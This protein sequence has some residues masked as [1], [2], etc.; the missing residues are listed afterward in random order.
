MIITFPPD[1]GAL[2]L[3]REGRRGLL[4]AL[5]MHCISGPLL[6]SA[7]REI[8]GVQ[9][10]GLKSVFVNSKKNTVFS[11]TVVIGG[12]FCLC[13]VCSRRNPKNQSPTLGLHFSTGLHKTCYRDTLWHNKGLLVGEILNFSIFFTDFLN[14]KFGEEI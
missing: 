12:S 4:C 8:G 11:E 5:C 13:V 2:I 7:L 1:L 9:K 3:K 14:F 6:A 10:R